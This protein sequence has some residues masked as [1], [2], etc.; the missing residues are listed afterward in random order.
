MRFFKVPKLIAQ[1]N[2]WHLFWALPLHAKT[3][4]TN[5]PFCKWDRHGVV[6]GFMFFHGPYLYIVSVRP[7][8]LDYER[9]MPLNPRSLAENIENKWLGS[10]F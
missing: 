3:H 10:I 2:I 9:H 7:L 4:G 8:M 1:T 5:Q 6:H